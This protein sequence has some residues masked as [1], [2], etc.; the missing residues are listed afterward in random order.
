MFADRNSLFFQGFE[1]H[2]PIPTAH[3]LCRGIGSPLLRHYDHIMPSL[4]SLMAAHLI[5]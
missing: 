3:L 5:H 4:S 1:T 2:F